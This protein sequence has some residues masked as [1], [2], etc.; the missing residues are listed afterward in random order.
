[1]WVVI[2]E[3]ISMGHGRALAVLSRY[4]LVSDLA[5]RGGLDLVFDCLDISIAQAPGE[6]ETGVGNSVVSTPGLEPVSQDEGERRSLVPPVLFTDELREPEFSDYQD[7]MGGYDAD[8]RAG[9]LRVDLRHLPK[10]AEKGLLTHVEASEYRTAGSRIT[11][12]GF[13]AYDF[14]SYLNDLAFLR[15]I[16][17]TTA[18]CYRRWVAAYLDSIE[19]ADAVMVRNWVV[20]YTNRFYAMVFGFLDHH[21]RNADEGSD[22][23]MDADLQM[24][25]F[26]LS[27]LK[28]MDL[29]DSHELLCDNKGDSG[30]G[31]KA[32]QATK[33]T[34][35]MQE[36]QGL[37]NLRK[38]VNRKVGEYA[39]ISG[40]VWALFG[41]ELSATRANGQ[42]RYKHG[43]ISAALFLATLMTGLRH[44][45]WFDA[46]LHES[47]YT[48]TRLTG[49][50]L[51][52][53]V[54]QVF[55]VK[56]DGRRTDNPLRDFRLIVLESFTEEQVQLIRLAL[57]LV[58]EQTKTKEAA[59]KDVRMQLNRVWKKMVAQGL[60]NETQEKDVGYRH[61]G[62][63]MHTARKT[64][65]EE[66]RR[67]MEYTR[68]ELAAMLGHT[69]LMNLKY[70]T[71]ARKFQPRTHAFALPR[72]WP[73]DAEGVQ[74]WNQSITNYLSGNDLARKMQELA[75][76]STGGLSGA[77]TWDDT[78][79]Y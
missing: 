14:V 73:G 19:H 48:D 30:V 53:P 25:S 66:V 79:R 32:E 6:G 64:F 56:Q 4:M 39:Y 5:R 44:A 71:K 10:L 49:M 51:S 61:N 46:I 45:E 28:Q 12:N 34:E 67:S 62:V 63:S 3:N 47:G 33:Q 20:P 37:D 52:C 77:V 21:E 7:L 54:L 16:T 60:I 38:E 26:R 9:V 1:M 15:Y 31:T 18:N 65:A 58:A 24:G 8:T 13:D 57:A 27:E 55:T 29:F 35:H 72:S 23:G 42:P 74:E 69:T 50:T 43:Q 17:E 11:D 78:L 59:M 76:A 41:A 2:M 36:A 68:F 22:D 75:E 70:Y 40:S